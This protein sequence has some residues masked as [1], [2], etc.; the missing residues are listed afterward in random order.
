MSAFAPSLRFL[1]SLRQLDHLQQALLLG[2][3]FTSH[4]VL[5]KLTESTDHWRAAIGEMMPLLFNRLE[6]IGVPWESLSEERKRTILSGLGTV[7][8]HVPMICFT[9]VP[10]GRNIAMHQY[11]FG[12]YG[13]VFRREWLEQNNADRVLYVGDNSAVSKRIFRLVAT[14]NIM[15]MHRSANGE[16]LFDNLTARAALDLIAYV[17]T[18]QNLEEL[19]WRIAGRHGLMG[20]PNDKD[21]RLAL[22]LESVEAIL[23]E[24]PTELDGMEALVTS[25]AADQSTRHRPKIL[26]SLSANT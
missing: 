10:D 20:G 12:R 6:Q 24:H 17:E 3:R 1:H 2:V 18:R 4:K 8:A 7:S 14:S 25:L 16:P 26:C 11:Q 23:V 15:G 13:L 19:E 9:E 5:F 22:T 21:C